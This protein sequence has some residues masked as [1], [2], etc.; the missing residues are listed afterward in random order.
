MKRR[1]MMAMLGLTGLSVWW[2]KLF[3]GEGPAGRRSHGK[4]TISNGKIG[5]L[6]KKKTGYRGRP[7]LGKACRGSRIVFLL[8]WV[9]TA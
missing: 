3:A 1:D 2:T 4:I 6:N 9:L 8:V 7:K 5:H